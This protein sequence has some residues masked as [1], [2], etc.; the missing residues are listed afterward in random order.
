MVDT[1]MG[2]VS[3]YNPY[4]QGASMRMS[5][6]PNPISNPNLNPSLKPNDVSAGA[7]SQCSKHVQTDGHRDHFPGE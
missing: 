2:I 6:N 4:L 7:G 5:S 1:R 3:W